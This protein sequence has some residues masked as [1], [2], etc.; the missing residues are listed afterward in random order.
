M[1]SLFSPDREISFPELRIADWAVGRDSE[2]TIHGT[3]FKVISM[4]VFLASHLKVTVELLVAHRI[5]P[6][7]R[8]S[9]DHG[10]ALSSILTLRTVLREGGGV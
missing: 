5:W 10:S 1:F 8:Q 9:I 2:C 4:L 6:S 3:I 7:L